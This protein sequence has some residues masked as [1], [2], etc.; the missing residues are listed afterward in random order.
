MAAG[1]AAVL[2]IGIGHVRS[3]AL[4]LGELLMVMGYLAQLYEPLRTISRKAASLQLHLASAER[5]FAL[6]DEPSDVEERPAA[7]HLRAR[8]APSPSATSPSPTPR[9]VLSC[10]TSPSEVEPGTRLGIVG[11]TG[12]GKTTLLSLLTRFYDPTE[13]QVL[14]DGV[15]LRDYRLDDLRR[16]FAVVP[17]EPV[18]FSVSIAENIAYAAPG[19]SREQIVAAAEA[20]NAHEF[21]ER[22]PEATTRRSGPWHEA[23]APAAYR[24]GARLLR[25]CPADPGRAH[26]R[27]GH[28]R[29]RPS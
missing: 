5:A 4:T 11:T 29:K 21:I 10:T 23:R 15:D 24:P 19:A 1:T 2:L 16:Q 6:L 13:G 20:A 9:I 3:G 8:A 12:A 26:E 7:W 17:Q 25:N 14:L 27:G 28:V 18:L 22:L